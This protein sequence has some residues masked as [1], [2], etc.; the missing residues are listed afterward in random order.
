MKVKA[1]INGFGRIGRMCLRASLNNP[2]LEVVAINGTSPPSSLAH[3]LKYDTVHGTLDA[4]VRWDDDH[5]IINGRA[6]RIVSD[7]NPANIYW[8]DLGVDVVIESTGKFNSGPASR[9]H[10]EN[11]AKKVV[12]T[13]PAKDEDITIVM[14]VNENKYNPNI[15]HIISNASCTTNCLGPVVKVLNEKFGISYGFMSTVH[16]FTTDQRSLDNSHKDLRRARACS[17][18]IVPTT[19]GA[20]KAIGIVMPELKGR[21]NGISIRVPV[22]DVSLVDLVVDL[23]RE[24]TV[25]E[26]NSAFAE[27]ANGPLKKYLQCCNEPLVSSDFKGNSYS[28]IIDTLSTMVIGPKTAKILA[29]YDN[30]WGYACRVIDLAEYVTQPIIAQKD[31]SDKEMIPTKQKVG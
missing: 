5:L 17:Q 19:T 14:G 9:I 18:S 30:E 3:L 12:I 24:I 29:W 23:N 2:N 11:G 8:G 25:K 10:L 28:A 6:I 13:A 26:I 16:A 31:S 22:P 1:G 27:A 15:H 20:A 21:L 7:R 4:D